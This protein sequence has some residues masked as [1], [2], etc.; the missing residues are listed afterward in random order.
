MSGMRHQQGLIAGITFVAGLAIY[1]AGVH[2]MVPGEDQFGLWVR[3]L[4]LAALC[5]AQLLRRRVPLGLLLATGVLAAD[6]ALGPSLPIVLVYTDFLYAATLYGSRLASRIMIGITAAAVVFLL[7]VTVF[8]AQRE[9][10]TVPAVLG[11]LSLV[12]VPVWWAMSVRGQRE[13]AESER[14]RA[15]QV[16][17]IAE[18]DRQAAVAAERGRMARDLHDIVAGHLSAIAIQSE[19]VLSMAGD[20][21]TTRSVLTSVRENSLGALTEMRAMIDVLRA[22]LAPGETDTG[23]PPRLSEL[24]QLVHTAEAGGAQVTV[25]STVDGEIP[26]AADFAAYRIAQEA[27]TNVVK[28]APGARAEVAIRRDRATLIVEVGN[29]LPAGPP[30]GKGGHG[31]STMRERAALVGG[32]L[33]AGPGGPGW[34]VHA[35]LPLRKDEA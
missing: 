26:S 21:E 34:L 27:L 13:V 9:A 14:A 18:L 11:L 16:A 17:R 2:R 12:L 1:L 33:T 19:A 6:V 3:A 31:L 32:T 5:G 29:D 35:E 4:E 24:S 22:D 15:D 25:S 28:H 7:V 8:L 20:P 30:R 23:V 10:G